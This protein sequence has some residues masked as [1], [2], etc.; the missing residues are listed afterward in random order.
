M[1]STQYKVFTAP[2][3]DAS[4]AIATDGAY[5][6]IALLAKGRSRNA[7]RTYNKRNPERRAL[8]SHL[9][10]EDRMCRMVQLVRT[11]GGKSDQPARMHGCGSHDEIR[12]ALCRAHTDAGNY[13]LDIVAL[14]GDYPEAPTPDSIA[15]E[16]GLEEKTNT[17]S[18]G[19]VRW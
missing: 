3:I 2:G 13:R 5:V 8:V 14:W 11:R 7:D 15:H 16:L 10:S 6:S 19:A 4:I 1:A 17:R 12:S 18:P 9:L